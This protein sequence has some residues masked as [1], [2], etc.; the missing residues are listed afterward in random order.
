[1][2][3]PTADRTL[4]RIGVDLF[5]IVSG[6]RYHGV[7]RSGRGIADALAKRTQVLFVDPPASILTRADSQHEKTVR[8]YGSVT[9]ESSNLTRLTPA[10]PPGKDRKLVRHATRAW[11]AQQIRTAAADLGAR[12][13]ILI[14]QSA[15]RL[16]LGRTG[17]YMGIYHATD[18]LAAGSGLLGLNAG[19]LEHAQAAAADAAD[20][21][22]AVSPILVDQW[23]SAGCVVRYLPNGV[24]AEMFADRQETERA[25]DVELPAPIAG[26]VGTLSERLDMDLLREV[27]Q[28]MSVL[29]VGPESF[30]I[31]RSGFAEL[32]ALPSVQWVG[33]RAFSELPAYY[34]HID[35]CLLPYTLSEFNRASFPLKS[36]EYLAAGK[37]VVSTSLDSVVGLNAPGVTIADERTE[38]ADA[39]QE[40]ADGFSD[41][42]AVAVS[43]FIESQ[44]WERR[45]DDL[46]AYIGEIHND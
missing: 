19:N 46:L 20:L 44:T 31:D 33:S 12:R 27:A 21:T 18:N 40:L 45:V 3:R 29:L 15:H 43:T 38:F 35:V 5:V 24:N 14:Q 11:L 42:T 9:R 4:S 16:V 30:R 37:P 25:A 10:A 28:R 7:R 23:A 26:V 8:L 6:S 13:T 22:V 34:R 1:M 2:D 36:L 39:A 32:I 17:E 41:E